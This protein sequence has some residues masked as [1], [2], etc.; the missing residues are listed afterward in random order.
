[1]VQGVQQSVG[2]EVEGVV[3]GERGA[4][5]A[6]VNERLHGG[7][8]SAKV[9]YA[10]GRRFSTLGDAALEVDAAKVSRVHR[11]DQVGGEQ[12]LRRPLA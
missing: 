8:G 4:V 9:E 6:E 3:I 1:V 2:A 7:W 12:R 10:P 11:L 5:D